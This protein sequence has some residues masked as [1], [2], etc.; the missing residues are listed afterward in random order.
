M[1]TGA[2]LN[3]ISVGS[4]VE[5][6]QLLHAI[7]KGI[8]QEETK[9]NYR[10]LSL[11]LNLINCPILTNFTRNLQST[12]VYMYVKNYKYVVPSNIN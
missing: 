3:I 4:H 6:T 10:K 8:C 5:N 12:I 9:N 1:Y 11:H 7:G 2:I